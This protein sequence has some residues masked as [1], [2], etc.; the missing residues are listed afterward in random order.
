MQGAASRGD[1]TLYQTLQDQKTA[2]A[3]MTEAGLELKPKGAMYQVN[4]AADPEHFLDWDKPLSE[5]SPKVQEQ[6][7]PIIRRLEQEDQSAGIDRQPR[8]WNFQ[9]LYNTMGSRP[10]STG[11]LRQAGIPGIKYLDQ[12]SRS[13]GEGTSNYVVFDDKLIDIIK[14]Y[15]MAGL[16]AGGGAHFSTQPVDHDPFGANQDAQAVH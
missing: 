16:I 11:Q 7:E 9:Q 2:L 15:G 14:K 13:S 8:T 4:I 5:Q 3:R 10:E 12:G 1:F 6:L